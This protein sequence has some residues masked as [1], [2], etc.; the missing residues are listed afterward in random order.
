MDFQDL[1]KVLHSERFALKAGHVTW[2]GDQAVKTESGFRTFRQVLL[3]RVDCFQK[4]LVLDVICSPLVWDH[5]QL[6]HVHHALPS[7]AKCLAH[8]SCAY[9]SVSTAAAGQ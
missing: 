2:T 7:N 9:T 8:A 4:N 6:Q 3:V 1:R 5:H